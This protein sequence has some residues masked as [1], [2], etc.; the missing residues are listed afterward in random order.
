MKFVNGRPDRKGC[1]FAFQAMRFV[2][3]STACV[4]T[5]HHV[6]LR[7]M[8]KL[9]SWVI[10]TL[11][12]RHW[13]NLSTSSLGV[14][15]NAHFLVIGTI[16]GVRGSSD[17][18]RQSASFRSDSR[19]PRTTTRQTRSERKVQVAKN[20][21]W[22]PTASLLILFLGRTIGQRFWNVQYVFCARH[23]HS[24]ANFLIRISIALL[25]YGDTCWEMW[26]EKSE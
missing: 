3:V 19:Q 21:L 26:W 6:L 2:Q 4:C 22:M 13:M 10:L 1:E 8:T 11:T 12:Q 5:F 23:C 16:L 18:A 25:Y 15:T 7:I 24:A 20:P 9:Q 17:V 14:T